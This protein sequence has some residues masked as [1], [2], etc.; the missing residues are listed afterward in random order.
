GDKQIQGLMLKGA[1]APAGVAVKRALS[2]SSMENGITVP[3]PRETVLRGTDGQAYEWG[4]GFGLSFVG[5]GGEQR[6]WQT[7]F[8]G[9]IARSPENYKDGCTRLQSG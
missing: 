8:Q 6:N 4:D 9:V 7:S 1:K 5:D 3:M 2:R